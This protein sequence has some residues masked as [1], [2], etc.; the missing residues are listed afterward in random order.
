[1]KNPEN[2]LIQFFC[3]TDEINK[4]FVN[5]IQTNQEDECDLLPFSHLLEELDE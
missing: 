2:K 4:V 3:E 1:M 5:Q